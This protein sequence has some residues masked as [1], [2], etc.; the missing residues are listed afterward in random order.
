MN[1]ATRA[2][3]WLPMRPTL[4]S[5]AILVWLLAAAPATADCDLAG[6]IEQELPNAP[7]A[8]VGTVAEL[9]GPIATFSVSEVWAGEVAEVVTV[10]G[11]FDDVG[12]PD[13]GAGAGFSEDD[14]QWTQGET[15]L[16]LPYIDG[17]VLRDN[18]CTPT[19]EWRP[20]LEQLRPDDARIL[21]G[22]APTRGEGAPIALILVALVAVLVAGASVLAFRRR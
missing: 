7:V 9:D 17:G 1:R 19:T 5:A 18:Q 10:R 12:R 16:V 2:D 20:E 14:R 4:V 22:R 6:P 8:F 11:L 13:G 3:V 21:G 15:Y